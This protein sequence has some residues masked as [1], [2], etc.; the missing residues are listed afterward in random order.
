MPG[1]SSLL[2]DVDRRLVRMR[3]V[4]HYTLP[5]TYHPFRLSIRNSHS[6]SA[7]L[8]PPSADMTS[9]CLCGS[10]SDVHLSLHKSDSYVG[11]AGAV[12][13]CATL[14]SV[15]WGNTTR[16]WAEAIQYRRSSRSKYTNAS[17]SPCSTHANWNAA[18]LSFPH[19]SPSNTSPKFR[20]LH[21]SRTE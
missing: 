10:A 16:C 6:S 3:T 17:A 15:S 19:F 13:K 20:A 7:C 2:G 8:S 14:P 12:V 4:L 21:T 11:H 9:P 1:S 18:R 5:K